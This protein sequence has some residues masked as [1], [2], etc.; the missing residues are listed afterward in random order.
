MVHHVLG[1]L[2]RRRAV[3]VLLAALLAG[4]AGGVDARVTGKPIA[5]AQAAASSIYSL[6]ACQGGATQAYTVPD[7]VTSLLVAAAGGAGAGDDHNSSHGGLGAL[8][9]GVV[10]VLPGDP[11]SII[12]GCAANGRTGGAGGD[13]LDIL[14]G[15]DG[16]RPNYYGDGGGG[17]GASGVFDSSG[18]NDR[19]HVYF[20]GFN[21][22]AGGGGGGSGFAGLSSGHDG[23]N[24]GLNTANPQDTGEGGRGLGSI[25]GG[26]GGGGGAGSRGGAGGGGGN[27]LYDPG[28]AGDGGSSAIPVNATN[29]QV[30]TGGGPRG[31]GFVLIT[32]LIGQRPIPT[33]SYFQC[34]NGT[35]Q[36]YTVPARVSNL[37]VLVD[38]ASGFD[39]IPSRGGTRGGAG[40]DVQATMPVNAGQV[41][42]I[43]VGCRGGGNSS[44]TSPGGSGYGN[45]GRAGYGN[46][47]T[48]TVDQQ[49]TGGGGGSAILDRT[50]QPLIVAGGGGGAGGPGPDGTAGAGGDGSASETTAKPRPAAAPA[51]AGAG[52]PPAYGMAPMAGA[53]A[54]HP[55]IPG[56]AVA[57]VVAIAAGPAARRAVA[58]PLRQALAAAAAAARRTSPPRWPVSALSPAACRA[59][60]AWW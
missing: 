12:V 36:S 22:V 40:A 5:A 17:G 52:A 54:V 28:R 37:Q 34:R 10:N 9:Q 4:S 42:G 60:M 19:W 44:D 38:G 47:G 8:V 29:T 33:L 46:S 31:D 18:Y 39:Q 55:V 51:V 41:L 25:G 49:G 26:G 56:P 2:A 50:G 58:L 59:A 43:D 15:G 13:G 23:H 14:T 1:R 7:G 53:R 45:G 57:V 30:V 16:G 48:G 20:Q 3:P 21:F 35:V 11:I 27:H 6:Y 32:P 24:A